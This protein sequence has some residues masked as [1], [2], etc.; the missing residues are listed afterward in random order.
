MDLLLQF[1]ASR[2]EEVFKETM[3]EKQGGA[4]FRALAA[5]KDED[6]EDVDDAPV[7]VEPG[8]SDSRGQRRSATGSTP[9]ASPKKKARTTP[10]KK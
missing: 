4:K 10:K 9:P 5:T 7:F 8:Q 1:Q 2:A 6:L 3:L